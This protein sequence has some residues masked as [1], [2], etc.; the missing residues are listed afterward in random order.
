M[1]IDHSH[2]IIRLIVVSVIRRGAIEGYP[3]CLRIIR[4]TYQ[5]EVLTKHEKP[6][7]INV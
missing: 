1:I 5:F 7:L 6:A 2:T 4:V 3:A